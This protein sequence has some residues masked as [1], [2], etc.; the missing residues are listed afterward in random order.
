MGSTA[1]DGGVALPHPPR[2][3]GDTV[4]DDAFIAYARTSCGIPFGAADGGLSDIFFLV[5]CRDHPTHVRALA[6]IARLLLRPHFVEE[7]RSAE[8][9][10]ETR[11]VILQAEE[12]LLDP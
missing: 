12:S 3:V 11:Q 10:A 4:Q 5:C 2:P 6:R 1:L 7:L 8:T 9:V